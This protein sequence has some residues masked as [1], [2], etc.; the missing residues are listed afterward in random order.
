M[1]KRAD[2]K[3]GSFFGLRNYEKHLCEIL[4]EKK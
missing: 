2:R 4:N 3:V 1:T